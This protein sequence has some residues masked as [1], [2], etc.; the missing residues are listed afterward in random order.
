M[1]RRP[2]GKGEDGAEPAPIPSET[3]DWA[4]VICAAY[5]FVNDAAGLG[6]AVETVLK[7]PVDVDA[8]TV[9]AEDWRLGPIRLVCKIA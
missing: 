8:S 1:F 5:E 9:S 3:E 7:T 4:E 6:C 2:P